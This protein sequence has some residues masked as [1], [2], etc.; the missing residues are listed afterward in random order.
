MMILDASALLAYLQHEPGG[1]LVEEILP[2]A[3]ISTV[4]WCE[5][6]QKLRVRSIDHKSVCK[7]LEIL[8]L[9]FIPFS[10]EHA[11]KAGELWQITS[12]FGLSLGD[13]ACLATGLVEQTSVM[14]ADKIW[15]EL[16]LP[17]EIQCI[18]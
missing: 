6:A 18:R 10:M 4:N 17:L 2:T 9:K 8:G 7:R 12:P 3:I 1:L 15:Q 5:V 16:T 11:D 13:R 14:T